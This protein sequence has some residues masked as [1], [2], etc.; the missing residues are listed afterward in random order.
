MTLVEK[1]RDN[2]VKVGFKSEDMTDID[3]ITIMNLLART[4]EARAGF[5]PEARDR[6]S[7]Q[8]ASVVTHLMVT[9]VKK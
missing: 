6:L 1:L 9:G 7:V 2:L 8:I 3:V 4:K 5:R